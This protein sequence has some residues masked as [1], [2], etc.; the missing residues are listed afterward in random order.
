[1]SSTATAE[2]PQV[3]RMSIFDV[4]VCVPREW[5]DDQVRS[6]TELECPCGTSNGWFIR[7]QGDKALAGANERVAC[8][9]RE[10]FV[11]IMLDA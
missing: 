4:Q 8:A 9:Q 7:K 11:H 2:Q 5:S 10:G 6:F 1:M 3:L